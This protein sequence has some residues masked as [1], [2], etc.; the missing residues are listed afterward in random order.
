MNTASTLPTITDK[1]RRTRVLLACLS[2]NCMCLVLQFTD[3]YIREK[4]ELLFLLNFINGE[5][6][7]LPLKLTI[8]QIYY[9]NSLATGYLIDS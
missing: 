7:S 6:F 8:S 3:L 2:Q 1:L 9:I 5:I 4:I